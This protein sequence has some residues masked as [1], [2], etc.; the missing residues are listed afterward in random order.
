VNPAA[1]GRAALRRSR[2]PG[3]GGGRPAPARRRRS[4]RPGPGRP[5]PRPAGLGAGRGVAQHEA[6]VLGHPQGRRVGTGLPAR[7]QT[8]GGEL[9]ARRAGALLERPQGPARPHQR[10]V[11]GA[12]LQQRL[13]GRVAVGRGQR[14]L[15]EHG[16]VV[17][18][19]HHQ[20]VPDDDPTNRSAPTSRA[21]A[22]SGTAT[23]RL[24]RCWPEN[25]SYSRSWSTGASGAALQQCHAGTADVGA[26]Q[27]AALVRR[28]PA[29]GRRRRPGRAP[30]PRSGCSPGRP[31]SV[32]AI[33]ASPRRLRLRAHCRTP[34]AA[35][36]AQGLVTAVAPRGRPRRPARRR[37]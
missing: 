20:R 15:P 18:A 6:A 36:S 34:V 4:A 2:A 14:Q 26:G 1:D 30:R 37:R 7:G 17:G 25:G 22:P 24:H 32:P 12:G 8:P 11:A 13:R 5:R 35:S 3:R 29:S 27:R 16:A 23:S 31:A 9:P 33:A 21:V 10:E 19:V 28:R